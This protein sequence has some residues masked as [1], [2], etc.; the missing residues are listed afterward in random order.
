MLPLFAMTA[1]KL[2]PKFNDDFDR[3]RRNFLWDNEDDQVA[4]GKCKIR[5][6]KV[7]SPTEVGDL[8]LPNLTLF[9]RALHLRWMWFEWRLPPQTWAGTQTP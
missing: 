4:G 8:G 7:C 3:R 5:W 1:L 2:Q 9:G 6:E